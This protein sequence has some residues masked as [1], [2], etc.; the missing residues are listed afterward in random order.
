[1]AR[2]QPVTQRVNLIDP[3]H[4]WKV[5]NDGW[6]HLHADQTAHRARFHNA[7]PLRIMSPAILTELLPGDSLT[8]TDCGAKV[9]PE[10]LELPLAQSD[11]I[12]M[13]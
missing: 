3:N 9:V 13:Y 2:S 5:M 8:C 6:K 10:D 7:N 4:I 1:M 12:P 11:P